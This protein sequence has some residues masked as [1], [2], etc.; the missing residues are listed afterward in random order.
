LLLATIGICDGTP[1][2]EIPELSV[3][4][5][6]DSLLMVEGFKAHNLM[7][8][9][10]SEEQIAACDRIGERGAKAIVAAEA[11]LGITWGETIYFTHAPILAFFALHLAGNSSSTRDWLLGL[12]SNEGDRLVVQE[13]LITLVPLA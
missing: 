5:D 13:E 10:Y 2:V 12:P 6:P 3:G 8:Q 4:S 7:I 11:K 1:V 9:E